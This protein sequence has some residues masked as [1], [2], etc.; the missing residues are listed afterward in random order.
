MKRRILVISLIVAS[1]SLYAGW[2]FL[3]YGVP[4]KI[5]EY[6]SLDGQ[7]RLE[8]YSPRY[9]PYAWFFRDP[10]F[11]KVYDVKT[12]ECLGAS[13]IYG[14]AYRHPTCWPH[15]DYPYVSPAQEVEIP[16]PVK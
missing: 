7:Y 15:P 16:V 1:I 12:G 3:I 13:T 6:I 2:P 11:S 8:Q 10:I 5:T 14:A 4:E 9:S